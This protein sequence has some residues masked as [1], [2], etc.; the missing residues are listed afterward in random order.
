M[1]DSAPT[2]PGVGPDVGF[3]DGPILPPDPEGLEVLHE[4]EYRVRAYRM[5]A[6]GEPNGEQGDRLLLRGAVRDQKPP[7]L[8]VPE[9][10]DPITI[11]HMQVELVVSFPA[12]VISDASV[13]FETHPHNQCVS[14]VDAYRGLVGLS[15]TRGFTHK[16]REAFGGPRGC[17]H[18]TA[19][20]LAMAPVAVQCIW[21]MTA[22]DARRDGEPMQFGG[23]RAPEARERSWAASLNSCHVWD[24]GGDFVTALRAGEDIGLPIPMRRRFERLGLDPVARGASG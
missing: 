8:Y 11:H 4:R 3:D 9:D 14:I 16:V 18:T 12:M 10:P 19:L 20:L 22:S 17:T 13:L 2:R 1:T 5:P 7:H 23:Q 6:D 24:E 15:I 21:S